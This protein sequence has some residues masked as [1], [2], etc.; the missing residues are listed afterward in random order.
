MVSVCPPGFP[1]Q[2]FAGS[3]ATLD[4]SACPKCA[5]A[6]ADAGCTPTLELY[7]AQNCG[8]APV[9]SYATQNQCTSLQVSSAFLSVY[10]EAGVPA[11]SCDY[12]GGNVSST[13]QLANPITICCP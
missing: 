13:A 8:G 2:T 6:N 3:A 7:A 1:T 4:C 11:P 5:L 12:G 10:D 9:Q